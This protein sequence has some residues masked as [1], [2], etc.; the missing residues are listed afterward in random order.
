MKY[1]D[2]NTSY[3]HDIDLFGFNSVQLFKEE[4]NIFYDIY[5]DEEDDDDD[6][7]YFNL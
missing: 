1:L 6:N 7:L 2:R 4:N 3:N 5:Y